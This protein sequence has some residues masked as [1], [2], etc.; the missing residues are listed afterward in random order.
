MRGHTE[1]DA[2]VLMVDDITGSLG[3]LVANVRWVRPGAVNYATH[4]IF[5]SSPNWLDDA[6]PCLE[7]GVVTSG[8]A[9]AK[10]YPLPLSPNSALC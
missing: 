8:S 6:P 7:K 4:A 10:S 2:L 5:A 3:R 1:K 9:N